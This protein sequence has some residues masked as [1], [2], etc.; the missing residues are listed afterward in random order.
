MADQIFSR[1]NGISVGE[2]AK[3]NGPNPRYIL[4]A[5]L[6]HW[7]LF[8]LFVI[9]CTAGAWGYLRYTTS[10]YKVNAK[11]LVKDDDKGGDIPG[12]EILQQLAVFSNK[13]SVDNE[14]EILKSRT[15]MQKVVT[16][17]QLN[18]SYFVEG[19]IKESEQYGNLPFIFQWIEL[20]D[21]IQKT[22]YTITPV[23]QGQFEL[24]RGNDSRKASW[25]DTLH[26]PEGVVR[27]NKTGLPFLN[28]RYRVKVASIDET[29]GNYQQQLDVRIPNKQVSTI[30]LSLNTRIPQKGERV[31]NTLLN[32]YMKA[33]VE[34]KN[35]I[36]DSTIAFID[37]RLMIVTQELSGVEKNIQQFKQANEI[38]DI[39]AQSKLLVEGSGDARKQLLEQ[40]VQ[41][42]VVSSLQSYI[43]DEANNK[44]VV[45]SSLIVQ[46][47]TF[48][49]LVQRYNTLQLERERAM[50]SSTA[51]NPVVVNMDQQ[52]AGIRADMISNL[53]SLKQGIEVSLLEQERN[54]ASIHQKIREVP[55]KERV[56]LDISRQQSIKQEL[57]LFLLKKREES[58]ISKTSNMAIA[59]IIDDAKSDALPFKPKRI[60]IL[61]LGAIMGIALPAAYLY[62][63]ELF[64]RRVMKKQDV[65]NHTP[66]PILAEIG[67][68]NGNPVITGMDVRTPVAEQ[69]R[70][71]RTNLQFVL[72]DI[73]NKC[74]ML[75]SSMGGEGKTFVSTNLATI[76]AI[77]GKKVILMEMDLRK[78][79]IAERLGI[80][81]REGFSTFAIGKTSFES[82]V[83]PSGIHE[84][85]Y[86]VTS[87]PIPPN[88]TELLLQPRTEEL[89][90]F[91]NEH[92]D[93]I[94]IDSAPI[95]LVTDA[96]VLARFADATLY[97][98]RHGVTFKQQ[99]QIS[100]DMYLEHKLPRI[101]IVINDVKTKSS[102]GYGYGSGYGYGYGYQSTTK[103]GFL[104]RWKKKAAVE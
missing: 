94:I 53:S 65:T 39:A 70:A 16:T 29:V 91:L 67:H 81:N 30:D 97:L 32:T 26:L 38:A 98:V 9:L 36:A 19:R 25:Q 5:F 1:L 99:L 11:I 42:N 43:R 58:A 79:K 52:L 76:L 12:Q 104:G 102:Y 80:S 69:F 4:D 68:G 55:G 75:T 96:Q 41:L 7:Y 35:R 13:S 90:K 20:N 40:Q 60:L 44:R 33:S 73:T 64:S 95:G 17:L 88:P 92:F 28:E 61:L 56:F 85:L 72:S 84:N 57:Y 24:T 63:R 2:P 82:L 74:V 49:G 14:V 62:C 71:L 47:P 103:K 23:G 50:M 8:L 100:R 3:D 54:A 77:S 45:P 101:N 89:F 10:S 15:L 86:L 83:Q 48:V 34:D 18:T 78:P 46:D 51:S 22:T 87:G 6:G 21:S 37:N 93:Y 66:V 27:I 31:L 59:R